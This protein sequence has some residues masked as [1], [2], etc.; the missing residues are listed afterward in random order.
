[1]SS[2]TVTMCQHPNARAAAATARIGVMILPAS[3]STTPRNTNSSRSTVPNGITT[4]TLTSISPGPI[5][6]RSSSKR[7]TV[8]R[9]AAP[10]PMTTDTP[11]NAAAPA[12]TPPG[13]GLGRRVPV[14]T[15]E[16]RPVCQSDEHPDQGHVEPEVRPRRHD[17]GA[18]HDRRG[19][20]GQRDRQGAAGADGLRRRTGSAVR[21][22]RLPVPP[23]CPRPSTR[24]AGSPP[25]SRRRTR[26]CSRGRIRASR[27]I[28]RRGRPRPGPR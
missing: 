19:E 6:T 2:T 24:R 8:S 22:E 1:M 7:P 27:R 11:A 28:P 14:P 20:H 12:T 16:R 21:Q 9:S 17:R 18:D 13:I 3:P 26:C 25:P 23:P 15:A 5:D 10:M 4:S